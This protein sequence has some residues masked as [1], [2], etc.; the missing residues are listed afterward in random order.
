M[1]PRVCQSVP[2][3]LG[4]LLALAPF[5]SAPLAAQD[6]L[7]GWGQNRFDTDA[8]ALPALD[9]FAA[10]TVGAVL[11]ADGRIFV[12]GQ[13]QLPDGPPAP[14][15]TSYTQI[16]LGTDHG[17]GLLSD[18]T[19]VA[20]AN[21]GVTLAAPPLPANTTYTEVSAG[22]MHGLARRSDGVAVAWGN[23]QYGQTALPTVPAGVAVLQVHAG[24]GHSLLRL[25]NGQIVGCGGTPA[26][27]TAPA[28]PA[29]VVYTRLWGGLYH[30]MAQRSDGVVVG[31][32]DNNQGQCDVLP[33]PT[34]VSY[35]TMGLG[36]GHTLAARSDGAV[37]GWGDNYWG[38]RDVPPLPAGKTVA[39]IAGGQ[40]HSTI[41]FTDGSVLG[42]GIAA[43]AGPTLPAPNGEH[44]LAVD[45]T[46][47]IVAQ[48]SAG[49]TVQFGGSGTPPALPPGLTLTQTAAGGDHVVALRS[50]GRA[51]AWG[52][53][54]AGQLAIPPL[55]PGMTYRAVEASYGLSLL[56]RSDGAVVGA[57]GIHP[58]QYTP[59]TGT[60]YVE[61]GCHYQNIL[62][63]RSDGV[64][65]GGNGSP[66]SLPP[67]PAGVRYV[68]VAAMRTFSAVL[69]SD[70]QVEVTGSPYSPLPPLPPGIVY[71]AI[72]GFDDALAARRSDGRIVGAASGVQ[73][74]LAMPPAPRPGESFVEVAPGVGRIGPTRTYVTFA[75]GCAGTLP[76]SRLVPRDTPYIGGTFEVTVFDLPHDLAWMVFGWSRV[77]PVPLAVVGMPGCNQQITLDVFSPLLGQA[78]VA[79]HWLPIPATSSLVGATFY[80]QAI[81]FDPAANATGLVVSDAAEAVIG[82]P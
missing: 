12:H 46:Y 78:G 77:P 82:R 11:R 36:T 62:L 16:T 68:G 19:I 73:D 60:E 21:G 2:L 75:I 70:G 79:K 63:R 54:V 33:L 43:F 57:G 29:G 80:H 22:V 45:G 65:L 64:I 42:V 34:G 56:L 41:R 6:A 76:A 52:S 49:R 47:P 1:K 53:N 4:I 15:G 71:V 44:W 50:D 61:I 20:W 13:T 7:R 23:N 40:Q 58:P 51:V 30:T 25:S 59:A 38:Q 28:L 48:T 9:V 37:V 26:R 35:T 24:A 5:A 69:R 8:Y 31:W 17:F 66:L 27:I 67:L 39:Q 10:N 74:P 55:P 18:G 72:R 3:A 32:G 81:V 14:A